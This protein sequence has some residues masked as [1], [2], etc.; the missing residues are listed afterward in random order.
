V[1]NHDIASNIPHSRAMLLNATLASLYL[2]AGSFPFL[3]K[4]IGKPDIF[5][6]MDGSLTGAEQECLSG[7]SCFWQRWVSSSSAFVSPACIDHTKYTWLSQWHFASSLSP[8]LYPQ[9]R[10]PPSRRRF[11]GRSSCSGGW[12]NGYLS[13]RDG[14]Q[15][16]RMY[17]RIDGER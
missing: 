8:L 1:S 4:F 5:H 3:V 9:F 12:P 6:P 11:L 16:A 17:I 7:D 13:A 10:L 14:F 2:L 15:G